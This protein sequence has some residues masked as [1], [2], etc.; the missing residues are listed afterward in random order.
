MFRLG[1]VG[2]TKGQFSIVQIKRTPQNA[3]G[4][5]EQTDLVDNLLHIDKSHLLHLILEVWRI[6]ERFAKFIG[7]FTSFADP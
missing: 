5:S 4:C 7:G 3:Q 2:F 6:R 1:A